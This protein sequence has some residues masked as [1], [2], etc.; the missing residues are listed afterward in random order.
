MHTRTKTHNGAALEAEAE[1][2]V[3]TLKNKA[4]HL[5]ERVKAGL[6]NTEGTIKDHPW[7]AVGVAAGV[8]VGVGLLVGLLMRRD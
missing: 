3:E 6:A 2:A 5:Q 8:G 7:A 1:H 4:A